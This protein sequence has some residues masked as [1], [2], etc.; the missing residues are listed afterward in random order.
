MLTVEAVDETAF[1]LT[2]PDRVLGQRLEDRPE[3]E[4]G[5][6]DHLED[7]AG[8]RL[9][10]ERDPQLAVPRLQLREQADVLDGDDGLVREGLHELDLRSREGLHF[11]SAASDRADRHAIPEDGYSEE[12]PIW[13][14]ALQHLPRPRV[15]VG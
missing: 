5:P 15:I 8:R 14:C 12:R 7:L 3:V 2:Q 11:A 4:G 10:L 6:A 9:L 1:G 13:R